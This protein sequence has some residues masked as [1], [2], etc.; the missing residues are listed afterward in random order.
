[1]H[2][3]FIPVGVP[4]AFILDDDMTNF[5]SNFSGVSQIHI[6]SELTFDF[7]VKCV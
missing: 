7:Q 1:M 2:G 3:S 5:K 6:M 4:H